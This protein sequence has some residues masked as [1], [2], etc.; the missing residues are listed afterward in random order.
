VTARYSALD[1]LRTTWGMPYH[2][3]SFVAD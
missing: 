1:V 3:L 2:Y